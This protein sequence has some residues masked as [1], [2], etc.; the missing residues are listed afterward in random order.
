VSST[1]KEVVKIRKSAFAEY[2][3]SGYSS[4]ERGYP[5]NFLW[6]TVPKE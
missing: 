3:Y 6:N 2:R 1:I 4:R 5:E